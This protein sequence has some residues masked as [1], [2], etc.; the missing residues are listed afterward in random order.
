[1][2]KIIF[3]KSADFFEEALPLGN[4]HMGAM[5]YGGMRDELIELNNDT[6][7]SGYHKD[8]YNY[9]SINHIENVRELVNKELYKKAEDLMRDKMMGAYT[10]AYMPMCDLKLQYGAIGKL[11][12]ENYSRWLDLKLATVNS[13]Y[14]IEGQGFKSTSFLS[15]PD[16]VFVY[17]MES[18]GKFNVD[19]SMTSK[20]KHGVDYTEDGIITVIGRC[21]D[22]SRPSY[23]E[24][25]NSTVYEDYDRTIM[26]GV[27]TKILTDGTGFDAGGTVY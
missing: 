10:E 17:S 27:K 13:V 3:D 8:K 12:R 6:L 7:W 5:V 18:D 20:L 1:M 25:E 21:P 24:S 2:N 23:E 4:G 9:D 16:N 19:I 11:N 26:F 22:V 15:Y 14:E